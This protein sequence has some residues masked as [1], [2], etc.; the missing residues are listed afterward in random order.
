MGFLGS[1][2]QG[3]KGHFE[4]RKIQ[5][6]RL[7]KLRR[8]ADVEYSKIFQDEFKKNSR[9]VAKAKAEKDAAEMSG[10]Q[11]LRATNR[12]RN[13]SGAGIDPGTFFGKFSDYTKG[14]IARREEN[15][16]KTE[17]LRGVAKQEKEKKME[18]RISQRQ[19][20]IAPRGNTWKM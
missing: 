2:S 12:A 3:I 20:R 16:K 1:I 5:Q 7:E 11:K 15:L 6:V 19:S 10:L 18:E 8:D 9:E 13:L 4:Q 17:E 14:N